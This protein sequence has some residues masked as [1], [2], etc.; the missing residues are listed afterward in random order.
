MTDA[1][2]LRKY[3]VMGSQNCKR[4]P[5]DILQEAIQGGITAFQFRE[6][7]TFSRTG[8][9]KIALGKQL[10][11]LCHKAHIPFFV[12]DDVELIEMLNVDGIHVGQDDTDV[13]TIRKCYPHLKIGLSISNKV[14]LQQSPIHLVD[15]VGAGP[16][17]STQTKDD[18]KQA[19]GID[20]IH[21]LRKKH[22]HLPIVGIG[23]INEYNAHNVLNAGANGVAVISAITMSD[24]ITETITAL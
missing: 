16:V 6:K 15:Y 19:V 2:Y 7:G 3:F 4:D 11:R 18:A 22:P 17:F 5:V 10:R 14:E 21:F 1:H 24:D 23:G 12:N 8:D 9:E 13:L 20:W